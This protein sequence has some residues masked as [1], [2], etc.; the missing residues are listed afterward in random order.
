MVGRTPIVA[1]SPPAS[2]PGRAATAKSIGR[3][4]PHCGGAQLM[5]VGTTLLRENLAEGAAIARTRRAG[6]GYGTTGFPPHAT[7]HLVRLGSALRA[8]ARLRLPALRPVAGN[9]PVPNESGSGQAVLVRV[10]VEPPAGST[11]AAAP[12]ASTA[13]VTV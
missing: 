5:A 8:S 9:Q 6:L 3:H 1:A 11:A 10:A 12:T 7:D 13:A 2:R 4:L